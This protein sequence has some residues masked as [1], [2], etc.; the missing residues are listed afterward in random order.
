MGS[1]WVRCMLCALLGS[2]CLVSGEPQEDFLG[3]FLL[4]CACL[5]GCV[6]SRRSVWFWIGLFRHIIPIQCY[7]TVGP[8]LLALE[9]DLF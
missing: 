2:F 4:C 5:L 9:C 7:G 1:G 6:Y 8:T 3:E